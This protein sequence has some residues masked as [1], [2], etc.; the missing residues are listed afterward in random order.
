[1]IFIQVD[2]IEDKNTSSIIKFFADLFADQN[3][4]N[5][6]ILYDS[7]QRLIIEIIT[8][9]LSDRSFTDK[10]TTQYLSLLELILRKKT[11]THETYARL[12]ELE[13]CLRSN[14]SSEYCLEENRY[15][16]NEIIR[17]HKSFI[18]I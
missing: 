4:T 13:F 12:D 17:Q 5:D 14:L 11:I 18:K 9:E 6:T 15:I 16:I 10:T 7:D 2:P 8:R 1:M 3:S